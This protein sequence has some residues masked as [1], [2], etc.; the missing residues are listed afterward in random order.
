MRFL[1]RSFSATKSAIT[2]IFNHPDAKYNAS[3]RRVGFVTKKI[4]MMSLWD[5]WGVFTPVTVL[6]AVENQVIKSI[7]NDDGRCVVEIG[8]DK[9]EREHRLRASFLGLF[10]RYAIPAKRRI[11]G[12][13]VSPDAILPSGLQLGV[14]HFVPGQYVDIQSTSIGKGFQG[15]MKRWGFKG[16]PAS[17]GVSL[18]HRSIGSTG[19]RTDPGKVFKGKKMPGR[20]GGDTI[21]THNLKV[22]F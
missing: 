17:H 15:G 13:Q 6:Q 7:K 8:V 14:H 12:F 2:D 19:N 16:L 10:K 20:M 3:S 9:Q 18:A 11:Y 22:R 1:S 5:E 21:S 4:G